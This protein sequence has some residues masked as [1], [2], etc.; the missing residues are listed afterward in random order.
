MPYP[1]P[2][3]PDYCAGSRQPA[4]NYDRTVHWHRCA[5]CNRPIRTM[6]K[7]DLFYPHV[8][9]IA[10]AR[11]RDAVQEGLIRFGM[12]KNSDWGEVECPCCGEKGY[13]DPKECSFCEDQGHEHKFEEYRED[14]VTFYA[15]RG[16][17]IN[18]G[19]ETDG[20]G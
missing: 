4:P 8:S 6:G 11:K 17:I 15:Y 2:D 14:L 13:D 16:K 1:S 5:V 9:N 12:N 18:G 3:D 20:R 10:R 7:T 19:G